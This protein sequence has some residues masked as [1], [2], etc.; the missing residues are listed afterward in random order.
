M[1]VVKALTILSKIRG[2]LRPIRFE[3]YSFDEFTICPSV[4]MIPTEYRLETLR[5]WRKFQRKELGWKTVLEDIWRLACMDGVDKGRNACLFRIPAIK[6]KFESLVPYLETLETY[7]VK[8][9]EGIDVDDIYLN[10]NVV[11]DAFAPIEGDVFLGNTLL[12]IVGEKK[13]DMYTWVETCL[14]AYL[15][16]QGHHIQ[17]IQLFHPYNGILYSLDVREKSYKDLFDTLVMF[18]TKKMQGNEDAL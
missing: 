18:Y 16:H 10:P 15:F 6:H 4:A 17:T 3:P 12:R 11:V 7:L 13:V 5:S 1:E 2:Q 14:Q 8:L 9:L